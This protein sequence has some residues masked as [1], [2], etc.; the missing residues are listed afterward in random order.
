MRL[1]ILLIVQLFFTLFI[2]SQSTNANEVS[3]HLSTI[4]I[5]EPIERVAPKYPLSASWEGRQGWVIFSLVVNEEGNVEDVVVQE[6]SNSKD[7]TK[8]ARVALKKWRYKPAVEDGKA[9]KQHLEGVRIDFRINKFKTTGGSKRFA[10]RYAKAQAALLEED[11]D[12]VESLIALM[13]NNKEMHLSE[14][15]YLHWLSADYE[16][17]KGDK[18]KQLHHLNLVVFG[19][20]G[21]RHDEQKLSVLYQT[22]NLQIALNRFQDAYVSYNRLLKFDPAQPD[23]SKF[24]Q[25]IKDVDKIIED[26]KP[27]VIVGKLEYNYWSLGL[28]RNEFSITD[29]EGSLKTL[30]VLCENKRHVYTLAEKNKWKLPKKWEKC[31][32]FVFGEPDTSFKLIEHPFNN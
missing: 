29:I 15:S 9:I 13:N 23:I 6:S 4:S 18:H 30:E 22:F 10:G 12:T 5:P 2:V 24:T 16:K 3:K 17:A 32:V 31:S 8:A 25:V 1:E 20:D 11:Y 19:L 14:N 21:L 28:T 7:L 27:I 26:E